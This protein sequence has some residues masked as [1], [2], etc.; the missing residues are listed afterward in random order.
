MKKNKKETELSRA[1]IQEWLTVPDAP[2]PTESEV[3]ATE[4]DLIAYAESHA[5]PVRKDLKTSILAKIA[6]LNQQSQERTT[7]SL[8]TPPLLQKQSNW[9]DW[10]AAVADIHAPDDLENIHLHPLISDDT[11]ELFVAFVKE[12]VPEEVHDD[13]LESFVI[14]EGSCECEIID[15][16]GETRFVWMREGDFI[17]FKIGEVHNIHI[18]SAQPVK[19]ILQWLK[20]AA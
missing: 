3:L 8:E 18:T 4:S 6:Q 17:D 1:V 16:N 10:Q 13:L 5:I 7:I 14:L 11:R 15:L 2:L 12:N 19:A 20:V 9:L